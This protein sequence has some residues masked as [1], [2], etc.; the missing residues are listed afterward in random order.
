MCVCLHI[1]FETITSDYVLQI[2]VFILLI[3][4]TIPQLV[5]IVYFCFKL[6]SWGYLQHLKQLSRNCTRNEDEEETLP[7]LQQSSSESV[8]LLQ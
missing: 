8:P 4:L 6:I 1:I 2:L 5:V 3:D 7:Q